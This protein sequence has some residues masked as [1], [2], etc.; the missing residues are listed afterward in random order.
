MSE[1]EKTRTDGILQAI[2]KLEAAKGPEFVEGLLA[3]IGIGTARPEGQT[4]AQA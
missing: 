2:D 3:G 4:E 1:T